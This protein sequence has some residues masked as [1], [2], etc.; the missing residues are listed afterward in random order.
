IA[1]LAD[2]T[3]ARLP[4]LPHG[5]VRHAAGAPLERLW[6]AFRDAVA[7][8]SAAAP[9]DSRS[10]RL[11]RHGFVVGRPRWDVGGTAVLYSVRN[12]HGFP[13]LVRA[14]VETGALEVLAERFLG[15]AI[16]VARDTLIFDQRELVRAV[17]LV[18][19]LFALDRRSGRVI[20][21]TRERRALDPDL[22]PDGMR[23]AC[24]I[25]RGGARLPAVLPLE[26]RGD[27][28]VLGPPVFLDDDASLVYGAPRFSPDGRRLAV[29]RHRSGGPWEIVVFDGLASPPEVAVA[30]AAGRLAD[31]EWLPDNRTILFAWERPGEPFNLFARDIETRDTW[32]VTALADGA[33]GPAVSPDGATLAYVGY[34]VEGFDLFVRPLDRAAWSP[35]DIELSI[36]DPAIR[37][38]V[39]TDTLS[40]GGGQRDREPP[41]GRSVEHG[42]ARAPAQPAR[43]PNPY[44]PWPALPP[45]YWLPDVRTRE[46]RTFVGALTSGTDPLGRHRYAARLSYPVRGGSPAWEAAYVYDRWRAAAF[47]RATQDIGAQQDQPLE[48]RAI[49]AGVALP[50]RRVRW[51]QRALALWRHEQYARG[52]ARA[53]RQALRAGWALTTARRYGYSVS[54]EH[55][56]TAGWALEYTREPSTRG[57]ATTLT[58]EIRGYLPAAG[59][60]HVVALRL[61]AGV[62]SGAASLRRALGAGGTAAP[63]DPIAFGRDAVGLIRGYGPGD[64]V[65]SRA[66]A[67]TGEYRAPLVGIERGIGRWPVFVRQLHW[68]LFADAGH[69]WT[70]G[71]RLDDAKVALGGE[72]SADAVLGY[73][74]PVTFS[75]GAAWRRDGS[76]RLPGG[77]VVFARIGHAF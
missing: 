21:L 52:A 55:G 69:A 40:R 23:V 15:E 20:R 5:A 65:G 67:M 10:R 4:Y 50:I 34:T 49:E 29:E 30:S 48:E 44:V 11:T 12:P 46:G 54:P 60:H 28:M 71:F 8:R 16:G 43:A 19:D 42:E 73:Y 17:A 58:G 63:G 3:A 6:A 39:S 64:A 75:I 13:S 37:A 66:V 62:S 70:E 61:A 74:A 47:V 36:E 32:R 57:S 38:D 77:G 27:R 18:S 56:V 14:R 26:R 76:G 1:E 7:G 53:D 2:R 35:I 25:H 31:P 68:A 51:S 9:A 72:L 24:V 59:R 33:R 41:P 45:R 22:A